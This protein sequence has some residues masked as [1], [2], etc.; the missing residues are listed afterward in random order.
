MKDAAEQHP[1]DA[2][3]SSV[4]ALAGQGDDG[5]EE[6]RGGSR[7]AR[8]PQ[9]ARSGEVSGDEQIAVVCAQLRQSGAQLD[10]DRHRTLN[11][12][13]FPGGAVG[14]S[15]CLDVAAPDRSVKGSDEVVQREGARA[16]A[17]DL[18]VSGQRFERLLRAEACKVATMPLLRRS[19]G[20]RSVRLE[21]LLGVFVDAEVGAEMRL[22]EIRADARRRHPDPQQA[23]VD[24]RLDHIH[25]GRRVRA[26][27]EIQHG[28]RGVQR[29]AALEDRA[30]GES[31]LLPG[32]QQIPRPV[33]CGP[34]RRLAGR[35]AAGADEHAKAIAHSLGNLT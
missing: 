12:E 3:A 32:S 5:F 8:S 21:L 30:G 23:L 11:L 31:A 26:L 9:G 33:D 27:G 14:R 28:F 4:A 18:L 10:A 35:G 7:L 6:I 34:H 29:E 1:R 17:L 24:E 25:H 2:F 15:H 13:D 20:G 22:G 19:P 16:Q